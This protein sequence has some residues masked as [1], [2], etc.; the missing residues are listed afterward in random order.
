MT[1]AVWGAIGSILV[2]FLGG[3]FLLIRERRRKVDAE[4]KQIE[5]AT[6][7]TLAGGWRDLAERWEARFNL[8]DGKYNDAMEK[9][10]DLRTKLYQASEDVRDAIREKHDCEKQLFHVR[11]RIE[12]L[13]KNQRER[14]KR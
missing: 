14:M 12:I 2:A 3:G 5:A 4:A 7:L 6:D 10:T 1:D 8:L 9:I 13:E 11:E